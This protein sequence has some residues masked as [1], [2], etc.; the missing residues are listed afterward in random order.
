MQ[1][2]IVTGS[3]SGIGKEAALKLAN[4]GHCVLMLCRDSEKS[5]QAQK[6]IITQSG[7]ENVVLLP[8]DLSNPDSIRAVVEK[9]NGQYPV[10]DVLVNNAGLYKV[11][12]EETANGVEMTLAVNFLAPF[13]L[14]EMLLPNLQAS[15][16]GRIVNVVSEL[17]KNGSINF[18]DLMLKNRYKAGDAYANS[19]LAAV[20]YTIELAQRIRETGV[21]VNALHPGVLATDAFR[22]Y[23]AF[24]MKMVGWFLE[25]PQKGGERIAHLALSDNVQH[26]TGE[27]FYKTEA[28]E[29]V[30]S[31]QVRDKTE[32]LLQLAENLTDFKRRPESRL[33]T[34]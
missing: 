24:I 28:R 4:A 2:I 20:L 33:E 11:K 15:G 3:N 19:K 17:Y 13:M 8:V 34:I 31:A 1:T 7:N 6:E 30:V 14:S 32:E 5:K 18:D 22:D 12:R 25:K 21:T 10:I 26:V 16:N 27:Y 29:L 23:P 9:I